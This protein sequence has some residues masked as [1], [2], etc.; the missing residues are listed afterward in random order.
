MVRCTPMSS[1][2]CC[3]VSPVGELATR[4]QRR[5]APGQRLR[6]RRTESTR[7]VGSRVTDGHGRSIDLP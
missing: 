2:T 4:L 6:A 1:A 3:A 5:Q 7:R